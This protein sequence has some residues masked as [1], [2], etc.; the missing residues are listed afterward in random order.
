[1]EDSDDSKGYIMCPIVSGSGSHPGYPGLNGCC[2]CSCLT[3]IPTTN[4]R[5]SCS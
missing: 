5:H 1:V 3:H 4:G 2:C